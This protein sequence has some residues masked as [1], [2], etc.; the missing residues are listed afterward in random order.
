MD[1]NGRHIVVIQRV[2]Q[3]SS[4]LQVVTSMRTI[5]KAQIFIK[6]G[7]HI[8]STARPTQLSAALAYHGLMS[9]PALLLVMYTLGWFLLEDYF[10]ASRVSAGAGVV[11]GPEV[12]VLL[13]EAILSAVPTDLGASWP[14]AT[15]GIILLL[16][17]A[18][19]LFLDLQMALNRIWEAPPSRHRGPVTFVQRRFTAILMLIG[20]ATILVIPMRLEYEAIK[21]QPELGVERPFTY[22]D[23]PG[24][25]LLLALALAVIYKKIP[26]LPIAWRDV[27]LAAFVVAG[28]VL[29]G[30]LVVF[31]IVSAFTINTPFQVFSLLTLILVS[32]NYL[33]LIVVLGAVFSRCFALVF[34][35]MKEE[36]VNETGTIVS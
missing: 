28:L 1:E 25:Y 20:L 27:L 36:T 16:M 34:G 23:E 8:W 10:L 29:L 14:L 7:A 22:V 9:L 24:I 13:N 11:L 2:L 3:E 32:V 30:S 18:S 21:I 5:N 4:K 17:T 12:E 15:I 26:N 19:G 35:S 31:N 6:Y 33:S